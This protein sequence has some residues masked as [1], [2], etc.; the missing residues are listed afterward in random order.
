M[1]NVDSARIEIP[2]AAS[3]SSSPAS[4]PISEWSSGPSMLN[5]VKGP[6]PVTEPG[7]AS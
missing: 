2:A 7:I 4:T 3:G 5:A 6:T 1:S